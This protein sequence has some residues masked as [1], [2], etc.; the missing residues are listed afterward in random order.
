MQPLQLFSDVRDFFIT[1]LDTAFRIRHDSIASARR[2][3][4]ESAGSLCAAPYLEPI[5]VYRTSDV[6]VEDL[7]TLK[8]CKKWLPNFTPEE[9]RAFTALVLAG[10]IPSKVPPGETAAR[11]AYKLYLHQLEMLRRGLSS[12]SPGIVTS[13]TGSGKTEAFLLPIFAA[14]SREALRWPRVATAPPPSWWLRPDG[15]M[16][17]GGWAELVAT[18]SDARGLFV[19]RRINESI[20]RPKAVRALVLYPM[21]ALVEDQLV[22]LRRALDSRASDEIYERRFNGNRIYFGRYTGATPGT[23]FL[24]H[25]RVDNSERVKRRI[26]NLYESTVECRRTRIAADEEVATNP[27][28]D[29]DLPFNF[30]RVD[31]SELISRWDMQFSPPDILITNNTMLSAMLTREVDEPLWEMTRRWIESSEDAYF[32]LVLDELHL[33]RG[34]GGTETG[35]LLRWLLSRLGLDTAKNRHKLRILCSSASLPVDGPAA[36]ASTTFLWDMFSNNGLPV[37][38]TRESWRE[39]V[40][41]GETIQPSSP[42][43]A[44]IKATEIIELIRNGCGLTGNTDQYSLIGFEAGW[45]RLATRLGEVV[46]SP[47]SPIHVVQAAI[48]GVANLV[49]SACVEGDM[50]PRSTEFIAARLFPADPMG[51]NA[52]EALLHVRACGDQLPAWAK[53]ANVQLSEK[54]ITSFRL[55]LFVR[56]VE[57]LFAAPIP[58]LLKDVDQSLLKADRIASYFGDLSVERGAR[59]GTRERGSMRSRF[60]EL[61][62]CECCGELFFGGIRSTSREGHVELLPSDPDPNELPERTK[63]GLF[64]ELS[65]EDFVVFWPTV[66]RFGPWGLEDPSEENIEGH[67]RRAELDPYVG[68]VRV[69]SPRANATPDRIPGFLYDI[70]TWHNKS[71][72]QRSD[73]G[74]AVPHQCPYCGESYRLRQR[75]RRSPIRNF[76]TG[77]AKTTQLLASELARALQSTRVAE[78]DVTKL[79]SFSDSRQDAAGA[80]LDIEKRH[81]EDLRREVLAGSL[82]R[83]V[84]SRPSS[85]QL[86]A[87]IKSIEET[88]RATPT[89]DGAAFLRLSQ[90]LFDAQRRRSGLSDDSVLLREVLDVAL[91]RQ[92]GESLLPATAQLVET[93]AHPTDGKGIDAIPSTDD[94]VTF[95]WPQLFARTPAGIVWATDAALQAELDD[96][97]RTICIDLSRLALNSIFSKTYFAFEEAGLAYPC[98]S[99]NSSRSPQTRSAYDAL[100]RIVADQYRLQGNQWGDTQTNWVGSGDIGARARVRSYATQVWGARVDAELEDF[101]NCLNNEGHTHG[102]I[103]PNVLR[104]R[105]PNAEDGYFRCANCGRVHLHVGGGFCTRCFLPLPHDATGTIGQLRDRNYLAKRALA[106]NPMRLHSEELTAATLSPGSRLRRFKG[107][108]IEDSDSILPRGVDRINAP[109]DLDRAARTIDVLCVT[110]TM[111]V[112][113][114]IGALRAVFQANMPPQRFNYQQRVGRAGRRGQAFALVLTVCRSKSHDLWYFR[115]PQKITGDQP[116]PPFLVN[117]LS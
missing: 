114:D 11:S 68:I 109:K 94:R 116:P 19:P 95:A 36:T 35:L 47:N 8:N 108:F 81:H 65:A 28:A 5:A 20:Q 9:A 86:D 74:T 111:E 63:L 117:H 82:A 89:S 10:L 105:V 29:S 16:Y 37:D 43:T 6:R 87:Q 85:S 72:K 51:M 75:G 31:G 113:V 92:T 55:H 21:N 98:F 48:V 57:G 22:R 104:L 15:S 78:S 30:P 112:G 107:I 44:P 61:L 13:G 26:Q 32:Y 41:P 3:L 25:P 84:E 77:F 33:H 53:L 60:F 46:A 110:T 80:A 14:I 2:E 52:L 103:Q 49:A 59:L 45:L 50:R 24:Y 99:F 67:W 54:Q 70:G 27:E 39:A 90:Q 76:R 71:R 23:G 83:V 17:P 7:P 100:L 69:V 4:L 18:A 56:A 93:G 38:G 115:N 64:E 96:A 106:G 101:I 102:F 97:Q 66:H 42:N 73:P 79:V 91:P 62:Y 12:L 40:V 34:T 58:S 88:L 1:Y